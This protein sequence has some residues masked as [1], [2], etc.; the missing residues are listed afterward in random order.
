MKYFNPAQ[1]F[2]MILLVASSIGL[3]ANDAKAIGFTPPPDSGAPSQATGGASR[4]HFFKPVKDQGAPRQA[5]GGASRGGFFQPAPGSGA[6][7]QAAGGASRGRFFTPPTDQGA[8][9]QAAGGAA[10]GRFFTPIPGKGTPRRA[11]G[12]ASRVGRYD[13]NAPD[14]APTSNGPAALVAMLPQS[15]SGT[16]VAAHPT[17]MVY[18]PD[19]TANTAVFSLKDESGTMVYQQQLAVSGKAGLVM[20]ALPANAPALTLNQNYQ[21]YMALQVD[22]ELNPSTPYV[23]GWI[24]RIAPS[25]AL[26][27]ALQQP[28]QLK[29]AE[30]LGNNGIWYDCVAELAALRASQPNQPELAKQW[31]ELLE[32]VGLQ[33]VSQVPLVSSLPQ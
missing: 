5:T 29:R 10:R 30:L 1:I 18:L 33:D 2:G 25:T 19:S 9:Q 32:S 4:G 28:D 26:A 12:G 17:I 6:P 14:N 21:W 24:Q 7:S 11:A 13:L 22:G 20:I 27:A 23:D 16:T 31:T 15:Y 8:P 3:V